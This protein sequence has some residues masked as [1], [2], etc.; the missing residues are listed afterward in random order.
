MT[1]L[2][3]TLKTAKELVEN[4]ISGYHSIVYNAP[5]DLNS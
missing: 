4:V 1:D 3:Y 2:D 5:L